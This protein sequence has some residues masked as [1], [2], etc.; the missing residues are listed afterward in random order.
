MEKVKRGEH[1]GK[2]S[3]SPCGDF[4]EESVI[5]E[6]NLSSLG[7]P[8]EMRVCIWFRSPPSYLMTFSVAFPNLEGRK[9]SGKA[10]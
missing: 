8:P 10:S 9:D 2:I 7:K 6:M 3:S 1:V 4:G 5:D